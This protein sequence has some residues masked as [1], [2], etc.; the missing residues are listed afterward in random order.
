ME[1]RYWVIGK[2]KKGNPILPWPIFNDQQKA[3]D[4][5]K[6]LLKG[7]EVEEVEVQN[8]FKIETIWESKN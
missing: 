1:N 5:A 2:T 8:I 3:I 4:Y 6:E 7:K